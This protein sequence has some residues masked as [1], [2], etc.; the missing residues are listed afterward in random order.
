VGVNENYARELME[1]HTLG[2]DGGYTQKD[3]QEVARCLTG[4]GIDYPVL[5]P[6]FAF[7][8]AQHDAGEKIVLGV[9]IPAGRGI[10]DGEQVLDILARHPSTAHFIAKKLVMHFVS[11]APPPALVDRAAQTFLRTDGDIREVMRTIIES[12]EFNSQAA[13]RAKVKTPFELVA[14][15]LRVMDAPADTTQRSVQVVARLGQPIFGRATPDGWP[16]RGEAW[17]NTGALMNRVNLGAQVGANQMPNVA[18]PRWAER[19]QLNRSSPEETV[20]AVIRAT[21]GGDPS[22]ATRDVLLDVARPASTAAAPQRLAYVAN[23]VGVAIGSSDFQR[24]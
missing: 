15:I 2:V 19:R 5:D 14:S 21:L 16:D 8:A 22:P 24:R 17:M 3:V 13:Y 4:W 18:V 12:H 1:L 11:D 10:E 20:D 6:S 23:L 7:H 9:H